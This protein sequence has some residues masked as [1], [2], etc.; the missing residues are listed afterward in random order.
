M[1]AFMRHLRMAITVLP[2]GLWSATHEPV[3]VVEAAPVAIEAESE[4]VPASWVF[5]QDIAGYQGTGYLRWKA[6][7]AYNSPGTDQLRYRILITEA[8][9]YRIDLRL[10]TKGAEK[11]DLGN[12]VFTR[13]DEGT[14]TKT[15]VGG[16]SNDGWATRTRLEPSHGKFLEPVYDLTTGLHTFAI[17]G[18]SHGLRIDRLIISREAASNVS[19]TIPATTGL[20]PIPS[21]LTEAAVRSAW[22]QGGLGAV[23]KWSDKVAKDPGAITAAGVLNSYLDQRLPKIIAWRERDVLV[24]LDLLENLAAQYQGSER[25]RELNKLLKNWSSEP[26]VAKERKAREMATAIYQLVDEHDQEKD[27]KRKAAMAAG[28][29]DGVQMMRKSCAG[30]KPL[31]DLERR[32]TS[33]KLLPP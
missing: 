24:A 7:N 3:V 8:G 25:G 13:V 4:P 6:P 32:L 15:L 28:I 10:N 2:L 11:S 12:D 16:G 21:D 33:S 26:V 31:A 5:E 20:P 14:W 18:R 30:T 1:P 29:G 17:S 19:D 9:R 22:Q 27:A 23:L